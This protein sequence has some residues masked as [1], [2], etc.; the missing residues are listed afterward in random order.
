M[1]LV[2]TSTR[3]AVPRF[4]SNGLDFLFSPVNT[5]RVCRTSAE[6][7]TGTQMNVWERESLMLPKLARN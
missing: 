7:R 1:S 5:Q 2:S 3:R 6:Q 4:N